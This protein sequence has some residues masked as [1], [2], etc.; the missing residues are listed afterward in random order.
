MTSMNN[1]IIKKTT[2][3]WIS[4]A[5]ALL[6]MLVCYIQ[7]N[8]PYPFFDDIDHY[9]KLEYLK[10]KVCGEAK[11]DSDVVYINI[12]YDKKLVDYADPEVG[13]PEG[14]IDITDREKLYK[15]LTILN[16]SKSY[17][18]IFVDVRFEKGYEDKDS[19]E[20]ST[21]D[22]KLYEIIANMQNIVVSHHSDITIADSSIYQKTARND[23]YATITSTN[24]VRYQYVEDDEESVP[25]RMYRE[26]NSGRIEKWCGVYI[27][28][29]ILSYN[30]PFLCIPS[31]FPTKYDENGELQYMNIGTDVLD[32]LSDDDITKLVEG[33][34]VIIG[35]MI[36]DVHDTYVGMQPG[37]YITYN[38]YKALVNGKNKIN[39]WFSGIMFIV[40]LLTSL[41][42]FSRM[43]ILEHLP[44]ISKI[45]SKTLH[46]ALSLIGYSVIMLTISD[47][48][49]L[50]SD[51]TYCIWFPS[52]YFAAL[53]TITSYLKL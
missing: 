16:N 42:M 26:I 28:D 52:I 51:D 38:A 40:Y 17:R 46:F 10:W 3:L 45:N 2:A 30:C 19:L 7:N 14:N 1:W 41:F 47:V 44:Y 48:V 31:P 22:K 37:S 29:G 23:Y 8:I 21:V 24:L 43:K 15:F 25:L 5:S 6:I 32:V 50:I 36:E 27:T 35:D 18:Y 11:R 12:A 39:W 13:M 33:K 34:I 20:G 9:S 4:I 49:Y 53:S